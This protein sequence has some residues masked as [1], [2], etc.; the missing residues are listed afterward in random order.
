MQIAATEERT[1]TDKT[2]QAFFEQLYLDVFPQVAAFISRSDGSLADAKDVFQEALLVFYEKQRSGHAA[3]HTSDEGYLF[4]IAKHLW[5]RK[6]GRDRNIEQ[7]GEGVS[8]IAYQ[9][10]ESIDEQRMLQ[11]V[12]RAGERCLNLLHAFYY[13]QKSLMKIASAFGFSSVRSATV[14]KY[15]CLEKIRATVK[16]KSIEYADFLK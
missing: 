3:I 14:Q 2:R 11:L 5:F 15:K 16:Q 13:E 4:G 10:E 6:F 9:T 1:I 12:E 7:L 8:D